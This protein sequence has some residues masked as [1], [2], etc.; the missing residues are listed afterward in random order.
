M[1]QEAPLRCPVCGDFREW[2]YVGEDRGG[3]SKGKAAVGAIAFGPIGLA[4]GALGKKKVTFFCGKC[5]FSRQYD[6]R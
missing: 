5:G 4:A 3:F 6:P 2:H 1:K